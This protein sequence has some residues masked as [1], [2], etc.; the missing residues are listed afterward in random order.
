MSDR[1]FGGSKGSSRS[2]KNGVESVLLRPELDRVFEQLSHRDRRSV[3]LLLKRDRIETVEEAL[4]REER[5]S[6]IELTH[7]HL[8]KL[9][10]SG[11]IEWDRDRGALSKGPRFDEI[12]PL[13]ELAESRADELP[14]ADR[15]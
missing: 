5:R 3:L 6:E 2:P 15:L 10:E 13:L 12:E 1:A 9:A 8:P 11:Y 4:A 7:V 14:Y